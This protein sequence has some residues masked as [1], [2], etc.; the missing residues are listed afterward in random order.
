MPA[1]LDICTTTILEANLRKAIRVKSSRF[2]ECEVSCHR[3][4]AETASNGHPFELKDNIAQSTE[5]RSS[6]GN[7]RRL[8]LRH[9]NDPPAFAPT[10]G[11]RPD[12]KLPAPPY[13]DEVAVVRT[14]KNGGCPG[15]SLADTVVVTCLERLVNVGRVDR[16]AMWSNTMTP[17]A[18]PTPRLKG[19]QA[20]G[21]HRSSPGLVKDFTTLD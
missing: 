18:Y 17:L 19:S 4:A 11:A 10:F 12:S 14:G 7:E 21:Y 13:L 20:I 3:R 1:P 16:Q 5:R 15:P 9:T 2:L 8:Y 6:R